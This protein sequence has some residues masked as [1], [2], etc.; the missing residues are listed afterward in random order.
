MIHSQCWAVSEGKRHL[1][2]KD[3]RPLYHHSMGFI[4][5]RH[6]NLALQSSGLRHCPFTAVTRV[7]IPLGPLRAKFAHCNS[8]ELLVEL[9]VICKMLQLQHLASLSNSSHYD[10]IENQIS[11]EYSQVYTCKCDSYSKKLTT[12]SQHVS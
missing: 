5:F 12:F 6:R 1:M 9:L 11:I 4:H 10:S 7:Q 3:V 2:T 8:S